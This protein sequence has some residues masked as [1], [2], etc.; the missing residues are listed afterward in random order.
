MVAFEE[1]KD[2]LAE[3]G[4]KV[5][6]ASVDTGDEAREV[7][8]DVSFDVGEGVTREQAE[9]D[10]PGVCAYGRAVALPVRAGVGGLSPEGRR[11]G[12]DQ[13]QLC[14]QCETDACFEP[15]W[16]RGPPRKRT[17]CHQYMHGRHQLVY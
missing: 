5:F 1:H 17:R 14:C 4:V 11:V 3:K 7:A 2:A 15:I 10:S 8:N 6:A 16:L 13:P 9:P 12:R